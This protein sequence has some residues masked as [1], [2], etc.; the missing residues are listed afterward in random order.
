LTAKGSPDLGIEKATSE[1]DEYLG[2]VNALT[3]WVR[4]FEECLT[5]CYFQTPAFD[6]LVETTNC[7]TGRDLDREGALKIGRRVV[8]LFRMFSVREGMTPE[9]DSFSPRL[10]SPPVDGPR[11]G[12]SLAPTLTEVLQSY[13]KASGWDSNGRPTLELLKSLDLEFTIKDFDR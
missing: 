2:R 3:A 4:Q 13:Y 12:K 5:Y 9:H 10:A 6:T 1:P 8:N 7:L 11:A